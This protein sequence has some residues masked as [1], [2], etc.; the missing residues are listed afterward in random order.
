MKKENIKKIIKEAL[1]PRGYSVKDMEFIMPEAEYDLVVNNKFRVRIVDNFENLDKELT[2]L[3]DT[4]QYDVLAYIQKKKKYF[5]GKN[6]KA[7]TLDHAE[8]FDAKPQDNKILKI[9]AVD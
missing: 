2:K 3:L 5:A 6:T 4:D 9:G 7:F 1:W 8:V